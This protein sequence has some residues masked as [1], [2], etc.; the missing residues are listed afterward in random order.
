M[1][2]DAVV[3]ALNVAS[4][5]VIADVCLGDGGHAKALLES[6]AHVKV[7][8]IDQD[9]KAIDRASERLEEFGS[10]FVPVHGNFRDLVPLLNSVSVQRV[11]GII[12]DLGVSMLQ[13]TRPERGFMFS[14]KGPL[15]MRMNPEEQDETAE[16]VVNE[17]DEKELADIFYQ[18]GEERQSR[19]IGR[20]I[21]SERRNGRIQTT[22]QLADIVRKAVGE[23]FVIKSLARVFQALRIYINHELEN[24]EY[25]L[26]QTLAVLNQGGR[27]AVIDYHSL[28]GKI[29]KQFIQRE[30]D[31]C[32]CPKDI[33][34]CVCG[35]Q[36]RLK[37][38]HKLVKP[39][40]E[41]IERTPG[42][43]SARLRVAEK[44]QD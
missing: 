22:Q 20:F 27:L 44:L 8:G 31:P 4:A 19:R 29:V 10:R 34:V 2:T 42:A 36:P 28:E 26:N 14:E 40:A 16:D 9:Q 39:S 30:A 13:I 35:R 7:I 23:R 3:E 24:L 5:A 38:V 17:L 43:R 1:L 32:I 12:A 15:D 11:D 33:P 6:A 25:F 21:V 18:Y 41:E 37:F